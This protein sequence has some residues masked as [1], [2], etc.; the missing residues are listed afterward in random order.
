[1]ADIICSHCAEPWDVHGLRHDSAGYLTDHSRDE[2][3]PIASVRAVLAYLERYG[4]DSDRA[5]HTTL[6]R[7]DTA[8]TLGEPLT[9]PALYHWWWNGDADPD[10][11]EGKAAKRIIDTAVYRAVLQ[12][13]GCPACGFAHTGRGKYRDTALNMIVF[14]SVTDDDPAEYLD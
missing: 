8:G 12:G 7:M 3:D 6:H 2:L 4:S 1:M 14:D 13:K 9:V 5:L 10:S 11:D